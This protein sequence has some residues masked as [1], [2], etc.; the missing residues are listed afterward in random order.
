MNDAKKLIQ[1]MFEA[2]Q[3]YR[4]CLNDGSDAASEAAL[5]ELLGQLLRELDRIEADI[6]GKSTSLGLHF[7]DLPPFVYYLKKFK[8]RL[9]LHFRNSD[10][11]VA[12]CMIRCATDCI[13]TIS[14]ARQESEISDPSTEQ[15]FQRLHCCFNLSVR[16]FRAYL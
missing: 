8:N 7:D 9:T 14:R 13:I 4:G 15:L 5:R 10:S 6:F 3:F 1:S 11:A 16:Y 2:L 12:A